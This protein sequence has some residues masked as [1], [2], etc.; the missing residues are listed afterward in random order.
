M[1]YSLKTS[2]ATGLIFA[3]LNANQAAHGN[4]LQWDVKPDFQLDSLP[5]PNGKFEIEGIATSQDDNFLYITIFADP[6]LLEGVPFKDVKVHVGDLFF[7]YTD[8][9]NQAIRLS[10]YNSSQLPVGKIV[11]EVERFTV[12]QQVYGQ[13]TMTEYATKLRKLGIEP[14]NTYSDSSQLT[15]DITSLGTPTELSNFSDITFL[16]RS[17]APSGTGLTRVLAVVKISKADLKTTGGTLSLTIECGNDFI[18]IDIPELTIEV[19]P[20]LLPQNDTV[21]IEPEPTTASEEGSNT[22]EIA[23]GGGV[24]IGLILLLLGSGNNEEMATI[25]RPIVPPVITP[26]VITVPPNQPPKDVTEPFNNGFPFWLLLFLTRKLK[27]S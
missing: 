27:K 4:P 21:T 18:E 9:T 7:N 20:D 14:F 13:G 11:S 19:A 24:A 12:A 16:D 23:L 25:D 22:L 17:F 15:E 1:K 8:G 3:L 2:I 6:Q 10:P 5:V 26:P